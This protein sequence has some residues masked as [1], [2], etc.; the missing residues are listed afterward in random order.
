VPNLADGGV[1][2]VVGIKENI[3]APDPLDDPVS[4]NQLPSLLY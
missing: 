2:A 4:G 1:D 3:L